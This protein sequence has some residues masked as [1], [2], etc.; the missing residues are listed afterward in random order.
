MASPVYETPPFNNMPRRKEAVRGYVNDIPISVT[1]RRVREPIPA[2]LSHLCVQCP[3]KK[4]SSWLSVIY[5]CAPTP[6]CLCAILLDLQQNPSHSPAVSC[7]KTPQGT[8]HVFADSPISYIFCLSPSYS[9]QQQKDFCVLHSIVC[10]KIGL[11][12]TS[13]IHFQP[14]NPVNGVC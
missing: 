1:P 3:C 12:P 11:C 4:E 14:G 10:P 13:Y 2:P 7:G 6:K 9:L 5:M 8:V